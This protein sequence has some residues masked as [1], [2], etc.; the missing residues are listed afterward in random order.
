MAEAVAHHDWAEVGVLAQTPPP[1]RRAGTCA[2]VAER[3]VTF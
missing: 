3:R 1:K 2:T